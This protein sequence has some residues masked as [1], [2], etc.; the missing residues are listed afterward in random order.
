VLTNHLLFGLTERNF[1]SR[2]ILAFDGRE[3]ERTELSAKLD[4]VL[5]QLATV[6][7]KKNGCVMDLFYAAPPGDFEAHRADFEQLVG[8]FRLISTARG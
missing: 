3:A 5:F 6:V 8:G 7:L 1:S 4:G 2:R